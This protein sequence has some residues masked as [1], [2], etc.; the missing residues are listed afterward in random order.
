MEEWEGGRG[1]RGWVR[2]RREGVGVWVD[3][4]QQDCEEPFDLVHRFTGSVALFSG[5]CAGGLP[6][7]PRCC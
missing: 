5:Q 3:A 4:N 7:I 1:E 6:S 2:K